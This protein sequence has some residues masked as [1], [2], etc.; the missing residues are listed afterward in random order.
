[1]V[2]IYTHRFVLQSGFFVFLVEKFVD[3]P[4]LPDILGI[5]K[6]MLLT[7]RQLILT[8]DQTILGLIILIVTSGVVSS[9]M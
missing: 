4:F 7:T 2:F 9:F 1:L 6:Y 5:I 3:M 8:I